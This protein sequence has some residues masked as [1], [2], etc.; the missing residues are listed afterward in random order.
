[1]STKPTLLISRVVHEDD[2]FIICTRGSSRDI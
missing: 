2:D 1:M